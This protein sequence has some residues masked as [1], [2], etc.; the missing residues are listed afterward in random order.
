MTVFTSAAEFVRSDKDTHFSGA[1][2]QNAVETENIGFPADWATAEIQKV[3]VL[4]VSVL[5]DQ[6][7]AWDIKFYGRDTHAVTAN[8]DND[9]F[10]K[11]LKLDASDGIQEAGANQFY[12]DLNPSFFPF[13]Y[14][15]DDRTSEFH[16]TLVNRSAVAKTAG[17]GGEVVII[18]HAVPIA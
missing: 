18:I 10:E 17:A 11:T 13:I 1:L 9:Y 6:Q 3:Q 7:L 2:A 15:D 16:I 12:Y 8:L 14:H 4:G 5:S